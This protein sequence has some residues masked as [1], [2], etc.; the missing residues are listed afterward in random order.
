MFPSCPSCG[1]QDGRLDPQPALRRPAS[2]ICYFPVPSLTIGMEFPS[3]FSIIAKASSGD[4]GGIFE[5][6]ACSAAGSADENSPRLCFE[7]GACASRHSGVV[8]GTFTA[9]KVVVFTGT[10]RIFSL[11][12]VPNLPQTIL[13]PC[14][15]PSKLPFCSSCIPKA[16]LG[17]FATGLMCLHSH[18]ACGGGDC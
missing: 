1:M 6:D 9:F 3:T 13:V 10:S 16:L 14:G 12:T 4:R 18:L 2:E 17:G 8:V 7:V 11:A 5:R 15:S